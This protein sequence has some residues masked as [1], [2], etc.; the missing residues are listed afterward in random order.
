MEENTFNEKLWIREFLCGKKLDSLIRLFRWHTA[1]ECKITYIQKHTLQT[2]RHRRWCRR[3]ATSGS[4]HAALSNVTWWHDDDVA[5]ARRTLYREHLC[6]FR[7]QTHTQGIRCDIGILN[8]IS[9]AFLYAFSYRETFKAHK[10]TFSTYKLQC[11]PTNERHRYLV[12]LEHTIVW[13]FLS[14]FSHP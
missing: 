9:L 3:R 13:I 10:L 11:L 2:K 5:R 8:W 7:V 12:D 14:I 1:M 6:E 4:T